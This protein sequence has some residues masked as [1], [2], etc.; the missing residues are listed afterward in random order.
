MRRFSWL[1][2]LL[3]CLSGCAAGRSLSQFEGT[4]PTLVLEE[5]FAG[6]T[7]ATGLFEDRF[8][9]VRRQFTVVIDGRRDGDDFILDEDFTYSDGEKQRRIWRLKKLP[10]G[11]YEGRADDIIGVASGRSAGNAFNFRYRMKLKT[12]TAKDGTPKYWTVAFDDW[13]FLQ[14]DGVLLNRAT[15][16][17]WGFEIGTITISFRRA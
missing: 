5:Y 9:K 10:D 15:I 4:K 13:L 2:L 7:L 3:L 1:Y 11:S 12:G 16:S 8:G 14:S 17:R 6:R